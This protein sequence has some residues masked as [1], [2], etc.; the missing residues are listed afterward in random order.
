MKK[1]I[2]SSDV[3]IFILKLESQTQLGK[4]IFNNYVSAIVTDAS[5]SSFFIAESLAELGCTDR[6]SAYF[7]YL[8]CPPLS[9]LLG[10]SEGRKCQKFANIKYICIDFNS[11]IFNINLTE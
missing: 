7:V 3:L 4:Y 10:D 6:D 9:Y 2:L 5:R 11:F 1:F 8:Y